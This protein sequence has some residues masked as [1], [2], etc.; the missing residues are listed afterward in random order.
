VLNA[1]ADLG[2]IQLATGPLKALVHL[3]KTANDSPGNVRIDKLE[4]RIAPEA[5]A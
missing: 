2:D 4:V 3:E 1:T 5:N